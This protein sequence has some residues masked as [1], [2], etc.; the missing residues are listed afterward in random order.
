[1]SDVTLQVRSLT[2]SEGA[3]L[4]VEVNVALSKDA[5]SPTL[6]TSG[7]VGVV[8]DDEIDGK[9]AELI[10]LVTRRLHQDM[11]M[12]PVDTPQAAEEALY[13]DEEDL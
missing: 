1:M 5:T 4:S 12:E 7:T 8:S 9:V 10:E 6:V 11:G 3:G 2:Y 13:D